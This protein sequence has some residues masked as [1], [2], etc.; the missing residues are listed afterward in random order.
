MGRLS[1][2]GSDTHS[3]STAARLFATAGVSALLT[4]NPVSIVELS[5][6]LGTGMTLRRDSYEFIPSVFHHVSRFTTSASLGI[7]L[8]LP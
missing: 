6:S 8:R 5:A 2:S 3:P 7:G 4:A 1:A